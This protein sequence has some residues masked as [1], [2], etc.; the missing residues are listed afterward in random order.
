MKQLN[1][2]LLL[3]AFASVATTGFAMHPATVGPGMQG[4]YLGADAGFG[5]TS[6]STCSLNGELALSSTSNSGFAGNIFAGYQINSYFAVEGGFG[7][8]P[9][10]SIATSSFLG[11]AS[12]TESATHFYAAVKGTLPLNQWSLFGKLGYDSMHI[13]SDALD[14]ASATGLL[15]A[16]GASYSLTPNLAAT[17][18]YNQ[19]V[20]ST[21]GTNLDS[22][23]AS[24][25]LTYLF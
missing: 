22:G 1:K 14:T 25:G 23:Y 5:T 10:V 15:F 12:E 13:T 18:S 3:T 24:V 6:C 11:D 19:I 8:L 20:D 17:A 21:A 2:I 16:A 7:V 4:F 9:S